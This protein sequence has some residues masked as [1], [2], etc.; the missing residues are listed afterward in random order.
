MTLTASVSEL[1]SNISDYLEKVAKGAK[2]LIRDEKKGKTVAQISQVF[3]FDKDAFEKS[4]RKVAGNFSAK[5][6]PEWK[7]KRDVEKWLRKTRL[8][9][10]RSF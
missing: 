5:N 8:S 7:T 9:S 10:N 4:L 3:S 2:V 1:R 6:H